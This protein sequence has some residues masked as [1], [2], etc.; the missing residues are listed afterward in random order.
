[1]LSREERFME[2]FMMGLRLREGVELKHLSVQG[3]QDWHAFIDMER[4]QIVQNE[5]WVLLDD[6]KMRLSREGMLRLN[7][8]IP[9][10]LKAESFV[11][12]AA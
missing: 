11:G 7:A 9:Y 12:Q 10:I 5:G 6:D 4:L 3:G 8:L 2:A 1:M